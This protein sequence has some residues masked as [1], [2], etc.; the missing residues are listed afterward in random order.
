MASRASAPAILWA[1]AAIV[2]LLGSFSQAEFYWSRGPLRALG[3][4][5]R[6]PRSDPLRSCFPAKSSARRSPSASIRS[7]VA[8]GF[9]SRPGRVRLCADVSLAPWRAWLD[10]R[11]GPQPPRRARRIRATKR[12]GASHR[13][14]GDEPRRRR[15]DLSENLELSRGRTVLFMLALLEV[16]AVAL[17]LAVAI[18]GFQVS[19]LDVARFA[20][21]RRFPPR[22]KLASVFFS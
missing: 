16:G 15:D 21:V 4:G 19:S 11:R 13:L 14:G 1:A 7:A 12:R 18:L 17:V 8:D 9:R 6:P 22:S 5:C 2:G 20:V 10:S 3:G